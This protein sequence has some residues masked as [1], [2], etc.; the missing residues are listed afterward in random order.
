MPERKVVGLGE[1]AFAKK[2]GG[3]RDVESLGQL[4]QFLISARNHGSLT[5]K[6]DRAFGGGNQRGGL[7]DT[8]RIDVERFV[9]IVAGKIELWIH[10]GRKHSRRNVLWAHR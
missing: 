9:G 5:G 8:L 6:N 4:H 1:D 3:D 10:L 7:F 2:S